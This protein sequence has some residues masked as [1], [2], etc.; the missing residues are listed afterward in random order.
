LVQSRER[1]YRLLS[2]IQLDR[3]RRFA[4]DARPWSHQLTPSDAAQFLPDVFLAGTDHWNPIAAAT[5][6]GQ[7]KAPPSASSPQN[8][9]RSQAKP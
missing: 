3:A 2:R 7:T 6:L 5:V 1:I 4:H 9:S 8:A